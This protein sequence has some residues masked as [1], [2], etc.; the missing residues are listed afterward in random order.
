MHELWANVIL[1]APRILTMF[2]VGS[3]L[4][5]LAW[6]ATLIEESNNHVE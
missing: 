4:L 6:W 3:T 2:A 1:V 5:G